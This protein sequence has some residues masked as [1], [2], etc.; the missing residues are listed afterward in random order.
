VTGLGF[1]RP[2]AAEAEGSDPERPRAAASGRVPQGDTAAIVLG[3]EFGLEPAVSPSAPSKPPQ[4][5][6][7]P[8]NME[9]HLQRSRLE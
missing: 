2:R 7:L 3:E 9:E 1:A 5:G 4:I 6:N 8:T